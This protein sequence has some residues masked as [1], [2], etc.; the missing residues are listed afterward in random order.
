MR[1][2]LGILGPCFPAMFGEG[3]NGERTYAWGMCSDDFLEEGKGLEL[4]STDVY[5][6][7]SPETLWIGGTDGARP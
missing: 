1:A 4:Y 6:S 3:K 7:G 5:S 2:C